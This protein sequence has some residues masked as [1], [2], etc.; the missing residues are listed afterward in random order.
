MAIT[1]HGVLLLRGDHKKC[2][3]KFLEAVFALL[4]L[5]SREE[6]HP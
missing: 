4:H 1:S 3:E 2:N 5:R 6:I